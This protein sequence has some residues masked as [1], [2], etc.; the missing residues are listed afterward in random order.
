MR[1]FTQELVLNSIKPKENYSSNQEV[2][3]QVYNSNRQYIQPAQHPSLTHSPQMPQKTLQSS[4]MPLSR[5]LP[6]NSMHSPSVQA[7]NIQIIKTENN[8]TRLKQ[9]I[10]NKNIRTIECSGEGKFLTVKIANSIKHTNIALTKEE[11]KAIIK[12]FSEKTRIPVITGVFK[13]RIED[14]VFTAIIS[15]IVPLRFVITRV[16]PQQTQQRV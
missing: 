11:I 9:L 12:E 7:G 5:Q 1:L 14:V 16:F 8:L 13:A 3:R 2:I 4:Q 6:V 15:N 10:S